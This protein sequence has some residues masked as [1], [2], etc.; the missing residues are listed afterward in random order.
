MCWTMDSL[1]SIDATFFGFVEWLDKNSESATGAE[2]RNAASSTAQLSS[3]NILKVWD[4]FFYQIA[5]ETNPALKAQ[6]Y[7]AIQAINLINAVNAAS[8]V[9]DEELPQIARGTIVIQPELLELGASYINLPSMPPPP[10]SPRVDRRAMQ[11]AHDM[12]MA[13]DALVRYDKAVEEVKAAKE[14]YLDAQEQKFA[15]DQTQ[16]IQDANDALALNSNAL[17][18]A[19]EFV[20]DAEVGQTELSGILSTQSMDVL[21]S[22]SL[23]DNA[24]TLDRVETALSKQVSEHTKTAFDP[25]KF[26]EKTIVAGGVTLSASDVIST[27]EST[28]PYSITTHE[29]SSGSGVYKVA[30]VLQTGGVSKV[31]SVKSGSQELDFEM[32]Q[33]GGHTALLLHKDDGVAPGT[34]GTIGMSLTIDFDDERYLDINESL[35]LGGR[36]DGDAQATDNNQTPT[37]PS[38]TSY[39]IKRLGIADYQ[40][41]EQTVCCYV[42]GEVSHIENVMAR[43]Y[44]ERSTR[45]LRRSEDTVTS[46]RQREQEKQHDSSTTDRYELQQEINKITAE[47]TSLSIGAS[48]GYSGSGYNVS[49]NANYATNLSKSE[50]NRQAVSFAREVTDKA[51]DRILERVREERVSKMIEEFEEQNRHGFDNRGDGAEHVSGVY[52]WVDKVYKNQILNYGKR[53]MYEFM[54]PEPAAFHKLG[55]VKAKAKK[56]SVILLDRPVDPRTDDGIKTH[57]KLTRENYALFAALYNAEVKVPPAEVVYFGKAFGA[58][59]TADTSTWEAFAEKE[60]L[61][62]PEGYHTE[63]VKA[64]LSGVRDADSNQQHG[65]GI[66]IGDVFFTDMD[67]KFRWTKQLDF[68]YRDI[69]HFVGELPVSSHASNFLSYAATVSIRMKLTDAAFEQWQIDTF[70]AIID[71]Y[72]ERVKDYNKQES[73]AVDETS[74]VLNTNPLFY[75]IVENTVLKK[76]CMSYLVGQGYLGQ[77]FLNGQRDSFTGI[78]ALAN[79]DQDAYTSVAKFMEQ[80]FEWDIMSYNL[81]PFYWG[82]RG[83]WAGLYTQESDDPLFRS[84]MQAG[85]ARAVVTVWPGFENAVMYYMATGK[86]WAGGDAPVTGDPLYLSIVQELK[87]PEYEVGTTWETRVPTSLT[88]LQKSTVG[89]DATGLPCNED[90]GDEN[91]F[92]DSDVKL[93]VPAS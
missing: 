86:V 51:T 72:E 26:F 47:S 42:P 75:R 57:K 88:I 66:S 5:A 84:F 40:K 41:V 46:E 12:L 90:C 80:A 50:A 62:L 22:E 55:M 33:T 24:L 89:L 76:A 87:T 19:F 71:A 7:K 70:K 9:P 4:N 81:Y 44:K 15:A 92:F 43:E 45:V 85:L 37:S 53:L 39:G 35:I 20:P 79:A 32:V 82:A 49:V 48:A 8:P 16:Y 36:T 6:L 63:R 28:I 74:Q 25:D 69:D 11:R 1:T 60:N 14:K 65:I 34:G 52:R 54:I 31:L 83:E 17:I 61:K 68:A 2:L 38:P 10:A 67:D 13:N 58:A 77:N 64:T 18:P 27:Y 93:D 29:T 91:F 30:V 78:A 56:S 59:D 23:L 21:D 73:A 3:A